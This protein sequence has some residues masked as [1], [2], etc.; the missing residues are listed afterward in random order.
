MT[1]QVKFDNLVG[2]LEVVPSNLTDFEQILL[3]KYFM[4][5]TPVCMRTGNVFGLADHSS[6]VREQMGSKMG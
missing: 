1:A 3:V 6:E 2:K 4:Q 5:S